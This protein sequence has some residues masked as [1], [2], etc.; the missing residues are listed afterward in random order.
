M[1]RIRFFLK[2]FWREPWWFKLLIIA[3]LGGSI[4]FSSSAFENGYYDAIAKAAAAVFFGAYAFKL[5][6]TFYVSAAMTAAAVL[7]L[8]VSWD[9]YRAVG[10]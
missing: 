1:Q 5:R 2:Q 7:C 4:L 10:G 3:S 9:L 8:Y 6:R